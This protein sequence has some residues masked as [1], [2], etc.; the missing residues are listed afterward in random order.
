LYSQISAPK[1]TGEV[2][3]QE[4]KSSVSP[5]FIN[6]WCPGKVF[7]ENGGEVQCKNLKYDSYLDRLIWLNDNLLQV[8]LDKETIKGFCLDDKVTGRHTFIKISPSNRSSSN[9]FIFSEELFVN[10]LGLFAFRKAELI[11]TDEL[12]KRQNV[13]EEFEKQ[14][15]YYFQLPDQ[16]QLTF[17]HIRKKSILD[18]FP[19]KRSEIQKAL[20]A[21]GIHRIVTEADL[22][23]V[24]ALIDSLE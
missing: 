21:H 4:I 9:Q 1:L 13:F 3:I 15:V 20:T 14:T 16:K 11:R 19:D 6:Y 10:K 5:C 17:S 23:R 7:L 24:A 12:R 8:K 18:L 22:I 2:Y